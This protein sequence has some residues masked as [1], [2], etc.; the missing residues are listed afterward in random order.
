MSSALALINWLLSKYLLCYRSIS[1]SD[2]VEYITS[3]YTPGRIVLAGAGGV[4]HEELVKLA[5]KLFGSTKPKYDIC[6]PQTTCRFTGIIFFL[7][8]S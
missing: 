6:V 2:L 8:K 7:F 3:Y 4:N 1:R 5:D